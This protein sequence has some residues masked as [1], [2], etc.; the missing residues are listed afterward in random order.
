VSLSFNRY[1]LETEAGS[2][3][4]RTSVPKLPSVPPS[5]TRPEAPAASQEISLDALFATAPKPPSAA[6]SNQSSAVKSSKGIDLLDSIF[7]SAAAPPSNGPAHAQS[8][9]S[10]VITFLSCSENLLFKLQQSNGRSAATLPSSGRLAHPQ[11]QNERSERHL[12]SLLGLQAPQPGSTHAPPVPMGAR[13]EQQPSTV[14]LSKLLSSSKATIPQGLNLSNFRRELL[15]H[16][17]RAV[18]I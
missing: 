3:L 2:R 18:N 9:S 15:M 4:A 14:A 5:A 6:S 13:P 11:P 10:P 17:V 8:H 7:K 16:F 1:R 12:L